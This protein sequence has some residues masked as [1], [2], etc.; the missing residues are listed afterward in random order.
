MGSKPEWEEL[1]EVA[2]LLSQTSKKADN[3]EKTIGQ[4][5]IKLKKKFLCKPKKGSE[6]EWKK[7]LPG[8]EN[9]SSLDKI[10]DYVAEHD[11]ETFDKTLLHVLKNSEI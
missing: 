5:K 9:P 4:I 3:I 7:Y 10:I 8:L 11:S 2:Y 6:T 1:E